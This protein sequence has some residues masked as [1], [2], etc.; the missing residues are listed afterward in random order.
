MYSGTKAL[1]AANADSDSDDSILDNNFDSN[2]IIHDTP[3][4]LLPKGRSF[5]IASLNTASL[6]KHIDELRMYMNDQQFDKSR[7]CFL[8]MVTSGYL[9]IEI[10]VVQWRRFLHQKYYNTNPSLLTGLL[11]CL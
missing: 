8:S 1:N 7:L 6:V 4:K 10:N 3:V 11:K 5:K 2:L 9:T